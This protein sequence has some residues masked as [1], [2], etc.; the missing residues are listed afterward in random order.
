[1]IKFICACDGWLKMGYAHIQR[2][3]LARASGGL[4]L[5]YHICNVNTRSLWQ[6]AT[7]YWRK[8]GSRTIDK[9]TTRANFRF[10]GFS[11][12]VHY[13]YDLLS[14]CLIPTPASTLS[15]QCGCFV[16]SSASVCFQGCR[17]AIARLPLQ[18]GL[19][20]SITPWLSC[21]TMTLKC[22]DAGDCASQVNS[23]CCEV[24]AGDPCKHG[25]KYLQCLQV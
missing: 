21:D 12:S 23:Q 18:Y 22:L 16:H 2:L 6:S 11:V 8:A 19:F 3:Q 17:T 1:M 5:S 25:E 7:M 15:I 14:V 4:K 9:T 10:F 24:L 20:N 13:L